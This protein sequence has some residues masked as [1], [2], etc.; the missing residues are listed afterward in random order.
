[1]KAWKP[2]L[3]SLLGSWIWAQG[4]PATDIYT[5]QLD[6][7]LKPGPFKNITDRNGYDNQPAFLSEEALLF[8]SIREDGQADIYRCSLSSGRIA[9][10]T[11]TQESE[12][13]PT[14][15]PDESGFST[16]R[17]EFD[18][19]QRLWAFP[20]EGGA[21]RLLLKQVKPVGYHAWLDANRVGLFILGE[22]H[23]LFLGNLRTQA[24]KRLVGGIGRGLSRMPGQNA[25]AVVVKPT[26]RSWQ[27]LRVDLETGA[28]SVLTETLA[29]AEDFAWTPDG[30]ALL[31][32]QD[33]KLF[34]FE[35]EGD[36]QWRLLADL[37][38]QGIK[39]VTRVAISPKMTR[40]AV[41]GTR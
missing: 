35:P 2:A 7:T 21:G 20:Y 9:R 12:Y 36:E 6:N 5:A 13:S 8:T 10:L 24:A 37:S 34:R 31:M 14:P 4:P 28:S 22:P 38:S 39:G 16:V 25:L 19:T 3:I 1:M 40:I 11:Y 33:A 41:V 26:D 27:I 23:S 18:G 15:L 29:N 32:A 17:V 30:K